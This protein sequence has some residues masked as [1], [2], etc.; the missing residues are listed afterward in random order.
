MWADASFDVLAMAH[1]REHEHEADTLGI[2]IMSQACFNPERG[3]DIMKRFT[4]LEHGSDIVDARKQLS[5]D[6][7]KMVD[8]DNQNA[9]GFGSFKNLLKSHPPSAERVENLE[10]MAPALA[11]LY[12]QSCGQTEEDKTAFQR[13]YH[14]H[15]RRPGVQFTSNATGGTALGY[16]GRGADDTAN[17]SQEYVGIVSWLSSGVGSML[18]YSDSGASASVNQDFDAA[19]PHMKVKQRVVFE[20]ED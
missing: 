12:R 3:V 2:D 13:A 17:P 4:R 16:E 7:D 19:I 15:S 14:R 11:A 18:G 6:D 1:S 5:E 8:K 9:K 20:M 10:Q